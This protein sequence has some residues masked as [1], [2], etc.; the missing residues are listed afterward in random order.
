MSKDD[1][2]T[3]IINLVIVNSLMRFVWIQ[4]SELLTG[5]RVK[6]KLT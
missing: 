6:A 5:N 2:L 4:Q 1:P 3:Y